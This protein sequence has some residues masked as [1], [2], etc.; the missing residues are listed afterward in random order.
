[1]E[2]LTRVGSSMSCRS[3]RDGVA[4]GGPGR[5]LASL[6]DLLDDEEVGSGLG[7]AFDPRLLVSR[8]TTNSAKSIVPMILRLDVRRARERYATKLLAGSLSPSR[9]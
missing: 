4:A 3:S 7:Y 2:T 6:A 9:R 1:M 5:S 8:R